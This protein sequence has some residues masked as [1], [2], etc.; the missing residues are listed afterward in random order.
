MRRLSFQ[1]VTA[2]Y[3]AGA[4]PAVEAVAKPAAA[5]ARVA[6]ASDAAAPAAAAAAAAAAALAAGSRCY[7]AKEREF[8]V[9]V[10]PACVWKRVAMEQQQQQ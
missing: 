6:A 2:N 10:S 4:T 7:R 5:A 9:I 1:T 3:A 8:W